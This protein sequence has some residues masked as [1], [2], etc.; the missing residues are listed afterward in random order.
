MVLDFILPF[1]KPNT[2]AGAA[3]P[4]RKARR[5][6]VKQR[7][8]GWLSFVLSFVEERTTKAGR[9]IRR[10][11][12]VKKGPLTVPPSF[13]HTTRSLLTFGI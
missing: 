6:P 4:K 5:I 8:A 9:V 1:D 10:V 11:L 7:G 2:Q 13:Q 3:S 12:A